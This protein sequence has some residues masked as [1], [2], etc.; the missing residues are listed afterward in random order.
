VSFVRKERRK[1]PQDVPAATK[2]DK[3]TLTYFNVRGMA[4]PIRYMFKYS[5]VDFED[6]RLDFEKGWGDV[7]DDYPYKRLPMLSWGDKQ[8]SQSLAIMRF[9]GKELGLNGADDF[10]NAKC[11][12]YADVMKDILTM[13]EPLWHDSDTEAKEK[14]KKKIFTETFPSLLPKVEADLK[15]NGG[16]FLIGKKYTWVDFL[17]AHYIESFQLSLDSGKFLEDFPTIKGHQ[18]AVFNIPQIQKW[19]KERPAAPY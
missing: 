1:M 4:E 6:K 17:M 16:K 9:V 15:A 3:Y 2:K 14:Q 18:E 11:D 19:I 13:M 8:L 7:K 5:E 12:E 10:E